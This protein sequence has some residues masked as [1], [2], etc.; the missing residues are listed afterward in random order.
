MAID[1]DLYDVPVGKTYDAPMVL[2]GQI[3]G[4]PSFVEIVT[5]KGRW[6]QDTGKRQNRRRRYERFYP[7]NMASVTDGHVRDAEPE[8]AAN[9]GR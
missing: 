6:Y 8:K 5:W 4:F 7:A 3:D 1:I 2:V 9:W